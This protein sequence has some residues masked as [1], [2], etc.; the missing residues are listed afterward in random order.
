MMDEDQLR[1]KRE[2]DALDLN[3][4]MSNSEDINTIGSR[5]DSV[6]EKSIE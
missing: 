2:L 4:T 6:T 1:E 5:M 3:K